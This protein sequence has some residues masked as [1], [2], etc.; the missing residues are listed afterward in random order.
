MINKRFIP[1]ILLTFVNTIGF[2]ILIPVLPFVTEKYGEGPLVYGALLSAYSLFQ[3]LAAPLIGSLSDKFGR[4]PTL[5]LS[6]AGTFLSWII[7][8][9]A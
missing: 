4:R 7:F 3:F 6:Q 1:V 2:S 9:A 5:I 8:G